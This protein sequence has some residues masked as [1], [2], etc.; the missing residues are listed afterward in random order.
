MFDA[1]VL[2]QE[3]IDGSQFSFGYF[4]GELLFRSKKRQFTADTADDLFRTAVE[5]VQEISGFLKPGWTYRGEY[6]RKPKHNCLAYDRVPAKNIILFDVNIG[7]ED[8][9]GTMELAREAERIGMESV[10]S[11]FYGMISDTQMLV[12]LLNTQSVLG[13]Q[14][15]EGVVVKQYEMF[16]EGTGKALMAKHVSEA[17]KEV[18]QGNFRR[19][20]PKPSDIREVLI[21]KYRNES[22]WN[23][24]IQH[25]R[26]EGRLDESPKDIGPLI[27]EVQRD[28]LEEEEEQIKEMLFSYIKP[29][30]TRGIVRGLPEWYKEKLMELQFDA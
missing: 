28:T 11:F 27:K 18:N 30:L 17:F 22:R 6:L 2:V 29:H 1:P 24:A 9:L 5:R 8:Y 14:K 15:I 4:D 23:K 16:D 13:G 21:Q 10:P 3:K 12:D 20:N 25:L 26:D 19:E 7:E